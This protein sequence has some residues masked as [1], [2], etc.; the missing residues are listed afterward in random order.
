MATTIETLM[1]RLEATQAKFDKQMAAANGTA[2]RTARQI[3]SKFARMNKNLG[4]GFASMGRGLIGAFAAQASLAR[5]Q[6]LIEASTRIANA[7]KVSGLEGEALTRVHEGLFAAAQKHAAPVETLAQLYSR[8]SLVQKELG[9]S[10]GEVLGFTE[11]VALALRAGGTS[12]GEASGALLQLA[13]AMG[14]GTV[15]AEEFNSILEGAPAIAQ[16]AAAG[17]EEAGGS[18]ARLR[19]LVI[20]GKV[21]SEAFFRAFEAGAPMLA[22]RLTGMQETMGQAMTR[23]ENSLI[24]AAGA[25]DDITKVSGI[26]ARAIGLIATA[27]DDMAASMAESADSGIGYFIGRLKELIGYAASANLRGMGFSVPI[28]AP[29]LPVNTTEKSA[30]LNPGDLSQAQI[31][32][33]LDAA[34]GDSA[35]LKTVSLNDFVKTGSTA[36]GGGSGRSRGGKSSENEYQRETAQIRARLDALNAESAALAG[37]NPLA[38]DY[39]LQTEKARVASE[40]LNAAKQAGLAITPE[41]QAQ[42]DTL[43]GAYASAAVGA[44]QLADAQDAV[45]RSAKEFAEFGKDVLSGFIDDLR[46]GADATEALKNAVDKLIDKLLDNALNALF[47]NIFS[48][49]GL[50]SLFGFAKGGIAAHGKPQALPRFAG[51][52]VSRSAAIF[53]EAGPEAAVPLPDGRNI[54]VKLMGGG[55]QSVHVTVGFD[56]KGLNL[57]PAVREV[58]QSTVAAAAPG[59]VR[60]ATAATFNEIRTRPGALR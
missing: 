57:E 27:T 11:N 25:F 22:E 45:K 2:S 19:Q 26:T 20:D 4:S 24:H 9:I 47:S 52:G 15:R 30:R 16:A 41:L 55:Q 33:R 32:S 59:M 58:A 10:S 39:A 54:P 51:G 1:V 31:A 34:F 23:L 8:L 7:L 17:L 60:A 6:Q 28:Q 42:I 14:S 3:E 44:D 50:G 49:G 35:P 5:A 38:A 53:G 36:K 43:A 21:S 37:L 46:N 13:Q 56:R 48:G 40:L 18:V 29:E 12:A